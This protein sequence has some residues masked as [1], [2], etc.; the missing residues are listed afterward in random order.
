MIVLGIFKTFCQVY[1]SLTL[2]FNK[3][4]LI[5]LFCV[6]SSQKVLLFYSTFDI[7]TAKTVT[8]P[9]DILVCFCVYVCERDSSSANLSMYCTL[10]QIPTKETVYNLFF[11]AGRWRLEKISLHPQALLQVKKCVTTCMKCLPVTCSLCVFIILF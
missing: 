2:R 6:C 1:F 4:I 11:L 3:N 5:S 7:Y 10:E 9:N 8:K